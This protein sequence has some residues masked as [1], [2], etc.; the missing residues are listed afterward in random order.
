MPEQTSFMKKEV[1][2]PICVFKIPVLKPKVGS[3]VPVKRES[4]FHSIC[5]GVNPLL[6]EVAVC[7]KCSY[8]AYEPELRQ[9]KPE[10]VR[11][12]QQVKE[13]I[14]DAVKQMKFA[15]ERD[16]P[17]AIAA[18]HLAIRQYGARPKQ[19]ET[20]ASIFLRIA[21]LYRESNQA[22]KETPMLLKAAEYYEKS[23]TS[24]RTWKSTLGEAGLLYL[25]GELYR[26]AGDREKAVFWLSKCISHPN[27][28]LR[29]DLDTLARDAWMDLKKEAHPAPKS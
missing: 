20:L 15:E 12:V 19:D 13:P 26:R 24:Q 14:P 10:E 29:K 7:P 3:A 21:W 16:I 9:I 8:A 4:D 1:Y 2:C 27:T 18:Y 25:V 28:K 5:T 11:K 6:Y 17:T 23:F 22:E